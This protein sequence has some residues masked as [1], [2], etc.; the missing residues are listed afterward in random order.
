M[1]RK[2]DSVFYVR[3]TI[4]E[5]IACNAN[6]KELIN[7]P[8]VQR[9]KWVMQ[10]SL[11]NQV[12]NGGTHSRFA[13]S[14]GAMHTAGEYMEHLFETTPLKTWH[15][16]DIYLTP[17]TIA[18]F[19]QLARLCGLLHD[20]GHGPFSH[21]FDRI[22]Y[23]KIY[24]IDDGGHDLARLEH[25]RCDML[26]PYISECG[27]DPR[28]LCE[29]WAPNSTDFHIDELIRPIYD[30]IRTIV[31]GPLGADRIDFTRRDSYHTGMLHL[32]TIPASRIIQNSMIVFV[33]GFSG[34]SETKTPTETKKPTKKPILSYHHK[35]IEDVVRTLDGRL[36][37]YSS[38]YFHKTSMAAS[39]LVE[40]M[41]DLVCNAFELVKL[42]QNPLYFKKLN[43]HKLLG[44]ISEFTSYTTI[45]YK[46]IPKVKS[47]QRLYDQLMERKLPKMNHEIRVT[48]MNTPYDEEKYIK[49]WYGDLTAEQK[50]KIAIVRTRVISGISAEKFDKYNIVFHGF[51]GN[52]NT[53]GFSNNELKLYKCQECLDNIN[54]TTPIPPYYI[55]RGYT[56]ADF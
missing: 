53:H 38:V 5:G 37:L 36:N 7:S 35:C 32:G 39:L 22:I 13:H 3:D 29:V 50:T 40:T 52:E 49:E 11:A 8:L 26:A 17:E 20:V 51:F 25:V 24:G 47:A 54:Y 45:N 41:M 31:E 10:L 34:F 12:Y 33:S 2:M 30:I 43:D 4:L 1:D 23:K 27:I 14:L 6:E 44:M 18:H 56:F 19:V 9:L 46:D 21:S 55:V 28:E 42:T 48:D 16:H 15:F